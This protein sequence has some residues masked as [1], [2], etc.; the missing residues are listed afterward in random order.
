MYLNRGVRLLNA[1]GEWEGPQIME[2]NIEYSNKERGGIHRRNRA[3][4]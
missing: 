2:R 1:D 4:G 3:N